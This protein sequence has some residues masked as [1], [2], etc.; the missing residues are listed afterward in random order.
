[1]N[2]NPLKKGIIKESIIFGGLALLFA[3][4]VIYVDSL[5]SEFLQK[6]TTMESEVSGL[7][8]QRQTL[9]SDYDAVQKNTDVY[10]EALVRIASPGMFIDRQ[11]VRDIFN[12]Y[13]SQFFFKKLS[14]DMQPVTDVTDDPKYARKTLVTVK[15]D[16]KIS[17]EGTSD[18]EVYALIRL[19]PMELAGYTKINKF[20]IHKSGNIDEK[21]VLGIRANGSASLVSGVIEFTWYGMKSPDPASEINKVVSV[22]KTDRRR[23]Q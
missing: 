10:K 4:V 11:A 5:H 12:I 15:S 22:K 18:D 9:E 7:I 2:V 1:M 14:V 6:K 17:F 21:T 23:R 3:G 20:E 16:V 19:L 13:R 8:S